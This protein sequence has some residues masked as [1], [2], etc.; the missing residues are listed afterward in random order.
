[1]DCLDGMKQIDDNSIDMVVCD[2]PYFQIMKTDWRGNKHIW[3]NQWKDIEE[4]QGWILKIGMELKRILKSN[5]S[6][7]IFADDKNCSYV[8]VVLDSL[9]YILNSITWVKPNNL[10]IKGW[11]QYRCYAPI[12]EKILFY[13]NQKEDFIQQPSDTTHPFYPIISY[14]KKEYLKA[15]N[16]GYSMKDLHKMCGNSEEGGGIRYFRTASWLFPPKNIYESYQK[17][18]FFKRDYES[19]EREYEELRRIFYPKKNYTDVWTFNIIKES[20][21]VNHPTQKPLKIIERIVKVSSKKDGVVFDPFMGSGTTA[22]ACKR[23]NRSFIGFEID[24]EYYDI[25]LK[26]LLN[27]PERLENWIT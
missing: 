2:P 14:L 7:Y 4:Y 23:L 17:T 18:G 5:G 13:S 9:F 24:K 3:D 8:Q 10:T 15:K 21:S 12:T 25:S 27:V 26:R 16:V 19:L 6:L 1:M 11:N 20:E 22:I